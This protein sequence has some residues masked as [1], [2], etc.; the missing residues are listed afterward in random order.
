MEYGEE[1]S[2]SADA[3]SL[4]EAHQHDQVCIE[5]TA[6]ADFV[7]A[8]NCVVKKIYSKIKTC[9]HLKKITITRTR[10]TEI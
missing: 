4:L 3:T 10:H 9:T 2:D 7:P 1:P 6:E 5:S 8:P